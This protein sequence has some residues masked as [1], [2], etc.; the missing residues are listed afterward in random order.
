MKQQSLNFKSG[1]ETF[2]QIEAL[3]QAQGVERIY[4]KELAPRQD[5]DRNQVY[6]GKNGAKNLLTLFPAELTYRPP[7]TST[8]KSKSRAGQPIVEMSLNFYWLHAD[9]S[10]HLAPHAKIIDYFQYPEARFSGFALGCKE[11]PDCMIRNNL[12]SI[13]YGRRLLIMGANRESGRTFGLALTERDDPVVSDFPELSPYPL[14]P[15][16]T[17]HVIGKKSG[18]TPRELLLNEL[19]S[20]V[21]KWHPSIRLKVKDGDPVPFKGHQGAGF[22]LEALLNIPSNADKAPD[23]HGFEIKSFSK[24]GKISLMTPTA[25]M[26]KESEMPFRQFMETYGWTPVK[27][28]RLMKVFNGTFR[29]QKPRLCE[30]INRTLMLDVQGYDHATDKFDLS[31]DD[32]VFI[33]IDDC[34]AHFLLSGWSFQKMLNSWNDKHASA[35]Y[36]EYEKRRYTGSDTKHDYE[37]RYTGRVYICEGTDIFAYLAGIG[38][39]I[40]YYDPGHDITKTGKTNQRPQWRMTVSKQTFQKDLGELYDSVTLENLK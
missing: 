23:K 16:L 2:D 36:V 26:G 34:N 33:R 5:N 1:I 22:T 12:H 21:G 27:D 29:Y 13:D 38:K 9:G 32:K 24:G 19:T 3:F 28:K 15:L 14:V 20:I 10:S 11:R 17:T 37:Y 25:D 31:G 4:V 8:E 7:S 6:L 30:H 35:C 18:V 39:D 40:I